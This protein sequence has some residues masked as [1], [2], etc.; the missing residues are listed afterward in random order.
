[1]FN[2]Y[3]RCVTVES[4]PAS[5]LAEVITGAWLSQCVYAVAKLN[6]A[7]LLV[8]GSKPV[9]ELAKLASC[10]ESALYRILRT[11][12][13]IGIFIETTGK[14]FGLT[15]Q[16][17]LLVTDTPGSLHS[18]ALFS[19]DPWHSD[20]WKEILYS[21]REGKPSF[22][23]IHGMPVFD[24]FKDHP[25][26]GKLFDETMTSL[27]NQYSLAILDAY[28]FFAA[29]SVI[30]IGGGSGILLTSILAKNPHLS[31]AVFELPEVIARW[32]ETSRSNQKK[33]PRPFEFIAGNFF[34]ECPA[35]FDLYL[36]KFI[37]HDWSD[38]ECLKILR[39]CR[40]AISK[41]GKLLILEHVLSDRNGPGFGNLADIEMLL[42]GMG[43]ERNAEEFKSLLAEAGF[44]RVSII[45]TQS[46]LS[47]IEARI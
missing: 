47:I 1:M 25:E 32:Q 13:S 44:Q 3:S 26:A 17:A 40:N 41:E 27:S 36:M 23:Q 6:I 19:G 31:G 39:H 15:P 8:G 10:N 45:Q 21:V 2:P 37:L 5:T 12:S 16:A 14:Q 42:F 22:N 11:L 43:K 30:D 28:D 33:L 7:D 35:G 38:E 9:A 24:Y 46:S 4:D 29:K 34:T 20:T 18:F